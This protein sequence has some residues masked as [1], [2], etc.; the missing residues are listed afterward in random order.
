MTRQQLQIKVLKPYDPRSYL[1]SMHVQCSL[2]VCAYICALLMYSIHYLNVHMFSNI[3]S[4]ERMLFEFQRFKAIYFGLEPRTK[5][6]RHWGGLFLGSWYH[7]SKS[8]QMCAQACNRSITDDQI[9]GLLGPLGQNV[10]Q[11]ADA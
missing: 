11:I 9:F 3:P 10:K 5:F 8:G 7:G 6:P 2:N 4:A 1:A